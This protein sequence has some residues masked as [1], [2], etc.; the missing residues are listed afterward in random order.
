MAVIRRTV[1]VIRDDGGLW[2]GRL[3]HLERRFWQRV[4]RL[5]FLLRLI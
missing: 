4:H 5:G 2:V 1:P 3:L